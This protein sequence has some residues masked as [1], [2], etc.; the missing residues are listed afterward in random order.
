MSKLLVV[1]LALAGITGAI[2]ASACC[3]QTEPADSSLSSYSNFPQ[4]AH[5]SNA[6]SDQAAAMRVQERLVIQQV[7]QGRASHANP[8]NPNLSGDVHN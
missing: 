6:T 4:A 3:G 7:Q 1:A 5:S 2:P 8:A